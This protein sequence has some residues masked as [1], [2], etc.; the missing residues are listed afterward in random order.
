VLE[1]GPVW[2]CCCPDVEQFVAESRRIQ[3][4]PGEGLPGRAWSSKQ[5]LWVRD[6]TLDAN[7][8]RAALAMK[9]RLKAGLA[10]PI[11]SGEK[12]TAVIE[13]FLRDPRYEDERLVQVIVAVAAQLDLVIK[14]KEA[15]HKL[16][17]L[18]GQLIHLQDEE[19][20]RIAAELHDGLG[21][22]LAII[23]N[24]VAICLRD[25]ADQDRVSEQL[26]EI[27]STAV[28]AI[29]EV[30][31]IAHNLRPYELDR[32]GL[33][34]AIESMVDKITDT[35]SIQVAVNF[36][37]I[38]GLLSPEAETS[39]YRIVQEGLNNVVKHSNATAASISLSRTSDD[40][41]FVVVKDNGRGIVGT[42]NDNGR[43]FGLT[44]IAE[45]VRML[46]AVLNIESE[47]G[48]GTMLSVR[49]SGTKRTSGR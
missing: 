34:Q 9:G 25:P 30:R 33:V 2:G 14:R 6:V 27:S 3:F 12:T 18:T 41:I 31:E 10:I 47:P 48:C 28:S 8:P 13:F 38:D 49:L 24:R 11:L 17:R 1:L 44:G 15:E 7:S 16:Q 42:T 43:S 46:G 22:S 40:D 29:D 36:D 45:R 32:L 20:R 23:R 21:Q 39:I 26:E 35:T 37:P 19:R 4:G 5:P